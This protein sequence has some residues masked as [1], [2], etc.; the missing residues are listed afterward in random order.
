MDN[1]W[2]RIIGFMDVFL[3]TRQLNSVYLFTILLYMLWSNRSRVK[4]LRLSSVIVVG[5]AV[6]YLEL[7]K[8]SFCFI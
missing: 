2:V 3:Q 5:K 8:V 7:T 1:M 6:L 4:P